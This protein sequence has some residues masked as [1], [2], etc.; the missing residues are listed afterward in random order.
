MALQPVQTILAT[1]FR[2]PKSLLQFASGS[3]LKDNGGTFQAFESDGTTLAEVQGAEPTAGDS[4]VNLTYADAHYGGNAAAV[5]EYVI[6]GTTATVT[7]TDLIPANATVSEV[8]F[9]L[10]TALDGTSPTISIGTTATA[11]LFV[12]SASIDVT[13]AN[14]VD[15]QGE[16]ISVG[17][18]DVAPRVTVGGSGITTGAWKAVI[19]YTVTPN[20]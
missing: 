18:S 15:F 6:T 7:G 11:A 13:Q 8:R 14:Q 16:P 5:K 2:I 4:F 9:F 1:I 3:I 19:F 17:G 12:A 20:T 10:T